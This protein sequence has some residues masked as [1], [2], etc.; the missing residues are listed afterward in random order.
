MKKLICLWGALIA[1]SVFVD[2][3]L[4]VFAAASTTDAMKELAAAFTAKSGETVRFN[5]ASSGALARQIQNGAPADLFLSANSKWMDTLEAAGDIESRIDLLSNR[6]V[7][8]APKG[9]AVTLDKTF[10]GRL[11]VGDVKSVPAGM[12]AK[13]ALESQGLFDILR[14]KMVMAS[15]VRSALM[16][17]ERAEADAGIVYSTD[18]KS[19]KRVA[20]VSVFPE[21]SHAPIRY[22]VAICVAAAHPQAARDFMA[23][24]QTD[25]ARSVFEKRGFSVE[26][27]R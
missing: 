6:L 18:A 22:P 13:E 26:G 17:V 8:I 15:D 12:Y 5:F 16:F 4:T 10:S 23:F 3:E 11:A 25:C 1:S 7:L 20:V 27:L 21:A 19:S 2:A 9:C 24:L 14:P